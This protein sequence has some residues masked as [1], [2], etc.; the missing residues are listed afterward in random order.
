MRHR[1]LVIVLATLVSVAVAVPAGALDPFGAPA[2]IVNPGC[3][4]AFAPGDVVQGGD[5]LAHGFVGFSGGTCGSTIHYFQGSGTGWTQANTPYHG[6]VLATAWDTTGSY[7]LYRAGDGL[8]I[9]KRTTAGVFTGGRRI[10]SSTVLTGDVVARGGEWWAVWTEDVGG[11]SDLF[12]AA[13][14]GPV[15]HARQRITFDPLFDFQPS[16]ALSPAVDAMVLFWVRGEELTQLRAARADVSGRWT[17]R[18]FTGFDAADSE[19]DVTVTASKT[20]VAW[21]EVFSARILESDNLGGTFAR[22]S[23]LTPGTGPRIAFAG[24]EVFVGW[25]TVGATGPQRAFVAE[26]SG[27]TWTGRYASPPVPRDQ[28]LLGLVVQGGAA[29]AIITSIPFRVYAVTET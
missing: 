11:Q 7:L 17:S 20:F 19:P 14:L 12:Q 8:R 18:S 5:G 4:F 13:T 27:A 23:F 21:H 25:T 24:G 26:R 15:D 22:H 1:L 3:S 10:S 2:E 6:T 9:T 29:T 16:L 28:Q